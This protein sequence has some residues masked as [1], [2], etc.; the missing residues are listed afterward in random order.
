MN[1]I[2]VK[3]IFSTILISI[4]SL[5]CSSHSGSNSNTS[6]QELNLKSRQALDQLYKSAPTARLLGEKAKAVLVFPSITKGGFIIGGQY[7]EGTLYH[8]ENVGGYYNSIAAS[9][10]LQAG[11]ESFG[12]VLFFMNEDD[13]KYINN[14]AGWEIGVGP[15][16]TIIDKGIANSFTTT[17]ARE[18]V[19]AFFF[20]QKG[21]M[22]GLG[23]QGN[24]ISRINPN[25]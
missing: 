19:F 18:G 3:I 23:I 13:I 2:T 7:G 9:W 22:A 10:G 20:E 25:N 11:I 21:L 16:I 4:F 12:Y 24:K 8:G 15:T 6:A 5:G 14:S 17:T 1:K